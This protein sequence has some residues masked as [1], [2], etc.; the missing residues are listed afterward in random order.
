L[1]ICVP[2]N[3]VT[4]LE[5]WGKFGGFAHAGC[6]WVGCCTQGGR[7]LSLQLLQTGIKIGTRTKDNVFVHIDLSVQWCVMQHYGDLKAFTAQTKSKGKKAKKRIDDSSSSDE[8]GEHDLDHSDLSKLS[9]EDFLYRAVYKSINPEQQLISHAEEYFRITVAEYKMDKLFDL[10]LTITTECTQVLN[11]AMN[12]FGY[13]V[14]KVVIRDI[15]P[16]DRVRQAMNDIV[17][18]QKERDSQVTRADAD[19]VSRIK[20]AEADAEVSRLHGEG[21]ALQR[22]AIIGG[23]RKSVEDFS[24][25]TH[26]DTHAVMSL[27]M[28]SQHTDMVKES[29]KEANGVSLILSATPTTATELEHQIKAALANHPHSSTVGSQTTSLPPG[30]KVS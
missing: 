7:N 16:E 3:T 25:A 23:L 29:I 4:P 22:Q 18:S 28:M 5:T 15:N 12:D 19:K 21:I 2:E 6:T 24:S 30:K 1:C 8:H 26:A 13:L 9:R 14:R 11:R 27:M 20:A 10:G 17:A